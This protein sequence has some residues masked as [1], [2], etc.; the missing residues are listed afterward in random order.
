MKGFP[1]TADLLPARI[2]ASRLR[3]GLSQIEL[4]TRLGISAVVLGHYE[5]G[6]AFPP[7]K[8][9]GCTKALKEFLEAWPP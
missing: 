2:T 6:I 1:V 3:A 7:R 9:G 8:G 5:R 4:A